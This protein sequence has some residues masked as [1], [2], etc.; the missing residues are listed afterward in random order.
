MN[1]LLLFLIILNVYILLVYLAARSGLLARF[2]IGLMGPA[3]MVRTQRGKGIIE[4]ISKLKRTWISTGTLGIWLTLGIM[5]AITLLLIVQVPS[6]FRIPAEQA[7]GAREILALPGINPLIPISYG[8]VALILAIVIHEFAHGVLA[9]AQGMKVKSLGMLYLIVPIGA[10]VEPDEEQLLASPRKERMRVYAAGPTSNLVTALICGLVFSA[11]F[12]GAADPVADGMGIRGVT[13]NSPADQA[14]L[15]PGWIITHVN[16]T[17][18][19]SYT[20]FTDALSDTAPGQRIPLTTARHGTVELCLASR[21]DAQNLS[22]YGPGF[23]FCRLDRGEEQDNGGNNTTGAAAPSDDSG[24]LGVEV[25]PLSPASFKERLVSPF[26][27][28]ESFVLYIALPFFGLSPMKGPLLEMY[29]VPV[30]DGAATTGY[31]VVANLFYWVMWIS[32]M[33]GLTNALPAVPL[34][35]GFLFRDFVDGVI[36]RLKPSSTQ[37]G[38]APIVKKTSVAISFMILGLILLQFLAPRIGAQFL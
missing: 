26:G 18:V 35:G 32:L 6:L 11:G 2:N 9:R 16:D 33:L 10:F 29:D 23:D 7:P 36:H 15:E 1:G 4:W 31:W 34:D 27:S 19:T 13:E 3:L 28:L 22:T 38:R 24:F 25:Y 37:E 8:I 30:P 12:V 5:G 20:Q 14:G 17:R 21:E